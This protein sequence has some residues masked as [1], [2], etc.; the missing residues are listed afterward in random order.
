MAAEGITE[1]AQDEANDLSRIV[2]NRIDSIT[3][4]LQVLANE[5]SIQSDIPQD[6]VQL[7]DAAQ[8]STEDLTEYY[9]WLDS[10]GSLVSASNFATASY[11]YKSTW[12]SEKPPFLTE[13]QKTASIYYSGIIKSSIDNTE[14]LY[15]SYPIFYLLHKDE[16]LIGTFRGVIVASI[17]L[18]MLGAILTDELSPTL[19]SDVSLAD[20][21]GQ[22]VYSVDKSA[23]GK[24]MF[25]NP[26][27]LTSP[28]LNE[29]D[30]KTAAVVTEFT[31]A[32]NSDLKPDLTNIT[33]GSKTVSIASHPII[34]NGNHF[35]TIY[36]TAPH[37][38]TDNVDILL[39]KQD[40]FTI[41]I[42]LIIGTVSIG[43][44]YLIVSWNKR[45]EA[46]VKA[47]TVELN[48]SNSSLSESNTQ[49]EKA[50][51]QL[52]VHAKLQREFV[53]IAA[54]ELRTPIMPILGMSDILESKFQQSQSDEI[55]LKKD[56]FEILSRNS[57]RLERLA[58]DILDV[59]R[60][61]TQSLHLNLSSFNLYELVDHA[62]NDIKNQFH[63][64]M[65]EYIIH[66]QK[67]MFVYAD[68]SKMLQVISN[69][70][71]NAS[72]FTDDGSITITAKPTSDSATGQEMMT[73][74]VS[75]T[76]IGISP[77]LTRRLFTKFSSK[78]AP[79]R[80]QNGSGL[81]LYISKG[82]V[83]AHGGRIWAEN[84]KDGRGCTFSILMPVSNSHLKTRP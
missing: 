71:S 83:E 16:N 39:S 47:R 5:P 57:R 77:E 52:K 22:I 78:V 26:V 3:S 58:T 13:P 53:D 9:M 20:V 19:E 4:N 51:E 10:N 21:S 49:L 64:D 76:G 25:E 2:I 79:D 43:L 17:R 40:I 80:G 6:V 60:I 61:E 74:S 45:L 82:I 44:A 50:N 73:L 31:K 1:G 62:V 33:I 56:E 70:L 72:K 81:G 23:V 11:Q 41:T 29:L 68:R 8:Y 32:S 12:Q 48:K 38:F 37:I 65:V 59:S 35:W 46:I 75:D 14:R 67:E 84:N 18:D 27:Y 54:H 69:L 24:N 63:K 28:V 7:F 66:C 30:D 36:I 42:L 55:L 15:I 34:H